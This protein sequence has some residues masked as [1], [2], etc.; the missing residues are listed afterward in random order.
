MAKTT[1]KT[2]RKPKTT[3][4]APKDEALELVLKDF[5]A[6]W[7]YCNGSWHDRWNDNY[8][9]Y[10]GQRVKVGYEGITDTFVPMVF[11]TVETMT[12]ALFGAKPKFNYLPPRSKPDQKTEILNALLDYYWDKDQWGIKVINT[13][14]GYIMLGNGVDYFAWN[15]DHPVMVNIPLRDFF[16]DPTATSLE[17]ARFMGRRYLTSVEELK[18]FEIVDLDSPVETPILDEMGQPTGE[19]EQSYNMKPKYKNLN[20]IKHPSVKQTDYGAQNVG[21]ETTDQQEKNMFYGSTLKDTSDQVEVIEWWGWCM[22]DG[23]MEEWVVS[24]AN[25]QVVIEDTENYFKTKARANGDEFPKGIMPFAAARNYVDQ[26]L[27][28]AMGDVDF[29]AD[30]QELLN[31]VTNQNIDSVTFTLNQMYT[32][33]PEYGNQIN[34]VENLPGAVY[35]FK[36]DALVPVQRGTVPPDAFNERVNIKNEI[37][38]TT[39]SNEIVKGASSEG[40]KA[41]ATEIQAQVAGASN[42]INL[43]ITQIENEYFHRMA[44]IVFA[45][46]R[47]YVTEPMMVRI[48]GQDGA[49]WEQFDPAEFADGEYEPR[50]QLDIAI[51]QQKQEQAANA[52]ELLAAF[53]G[54]PEVN[55]SELKKLVLARGFDLDP[56]EV[57]ALMTPDPMQMQQQMAMGGMMGGATPGMTPDPMSEIPPEALLQL[58][59]DATPEELEMVR[60]AAMAEQGAM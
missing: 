18:E 20:K 33:D 24:V 54:D 53:L 9:L 58:P 50:V 48:V 31:D 29:I 13:G 57:D 39:A 19:V 35:P 8:S 4:T 17:N 26:S 55:Q 51:E 34:E 52:K 44:R 2:T 46:V 37:R 1:P 23:K 36:K 27:F 30:Q 10:H 6:A 11:S 49:R 25:R 15:G 14:R 41:T 12:S 47:L 16:I 5:Q 28:Y 21:A 60:Q 45:M 38:E 59:P 22:R 32:L 56:D 3:E 42:R 40:G 7:D 43:K